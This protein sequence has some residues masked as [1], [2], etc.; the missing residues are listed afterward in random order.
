MG[1]QRDQSAIVRRRRTTTWVVGHCVDLLNAAA[2]VDQVEVG[3]REGDERENGNE[4][5]DERHGG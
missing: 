5:A 1:R 4:G 3:R 2:W